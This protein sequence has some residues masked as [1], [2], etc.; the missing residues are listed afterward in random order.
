MPNIFWQFQ[1]ENYEKKKTVKVPAILA[2]FFIFFGK[3]IF[4]RAWRRKTFC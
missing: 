1:R 2:L 3:T 4:F